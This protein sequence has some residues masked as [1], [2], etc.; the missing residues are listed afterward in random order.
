MKNKFYAIILM[1]LFLIAA[2]AFHYDGSQSRANATENSNKVSEINA[3]ETQHLIN[4][5]SKQ[6]E[7][8]IIIDGERF[9]NI[10]EEEKFADL[11]KIAQDSDANLYAIPNSGQFAIVKDGTPIFRMST[12]IKAAS[13]DHVHILSE[14]FAI[15]GME[16]FNNLPKNIDQVLKTGEE[17][18]VELSEYEGYVVYQ[19]DG[20]IIVSW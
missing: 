8:E 13:V 2:G 14:A 10:M 9:E 12:G 6:A 17:V 11:S 18:Y 3:G 7:N 16:E 1:S 5:N 15:G 19:E 4:R 20:W